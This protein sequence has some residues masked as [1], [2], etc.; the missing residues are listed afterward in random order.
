MREALKLLWLSIMSGDLLRMKEIG[1]TLIKAG[2]SL[3]SASLNKYDWTPLH[4]ACY[5]GR[6]E[7][8]KYLVETHHVDVN[9]Q[10]A[11]GWHSLTMTVMGSSL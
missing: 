2:G 1:K 7:I 3:S 4:A 5:F 6:L 11:Y 10:N 9:A 8:V